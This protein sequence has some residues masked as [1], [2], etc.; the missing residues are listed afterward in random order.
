MP[1]NDLGIVNIAA[2]SPKTAI[3]LEES[4][5]VRADANGLLAATV[6]GQAIPKATLHIFSVRLDGDLTSTVKNTGRLPLVRSRLDRWRSD[7]EGVQLFDVARNI[8]TL[9]RGAQ[10]QL[11][12][13][14]AVQGALQVLWSLVTVLFTGKAVVKQWVEL[15]AVGY[16]KGAT[17]TVI[18][19]VGAVGVAWD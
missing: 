17:M 4:G 9:R 16:S 15:S 18:A 19:P 14:W 10:V 8:G 7:A 11:K 12:Q 2:E 1:S 3:V 5:E 13:G 6:G